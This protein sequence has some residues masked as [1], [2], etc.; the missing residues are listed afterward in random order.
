MDPFNS[1]LGIEK[2]S[3]AE[4]ISHI[5]EEL[6][7]ENWDDLT[8][9]G[10]KDMLEATVNNSEILAED[11]GTET[12]LSA[13]QKIPRTIAFTVLAFTQMFEVMAIHA[14]D[15]ISFFKGWF[16]SNH[17]LLWA[18]LSTFALQLIVIYVPFFQRTFETVPLSVLDLIIS[19]ILGAVILFAVEIE[20]LFINY[21]NERQ[22][23]QKAA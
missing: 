5:D 10:R 11:Q 14:G 21:M 13:I 23:A 2:M 1:T 15:K 20:K 9:S 18:V 17:L 7:P 22:S 8:E 12:N 3:R 4:F 19:F 16:R 6:L